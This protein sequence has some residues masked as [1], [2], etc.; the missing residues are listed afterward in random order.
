MAMSNVHDKRPQ[1]TPRTPKIVQDDRAIVGI[2]CMWAKDELAQFMV[3]YSGPEVDVRTFFNEPDKWF[4][5]SSLETYH[6]G[7]YTFLLSETCWA[8]DAAKSQL[9]AIESRNEMTRGF[10][11]QHAPWWDSVFLA[12]KNINV[13]ETLSRVENLSKKRREKNAARRARRAERKS[14]SL[15]ASQRR[16]RGIQPEPGTSSAVIG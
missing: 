7:V 9:L 1:R 11:L 14:P 10:L 5:F 4:D 15:A 16:N 2:S 3:E 8:D 6:T 13:F 12:W